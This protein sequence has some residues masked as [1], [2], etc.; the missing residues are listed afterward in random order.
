MGP[1]KIYSKNFDSAVIVF[2]Q[3]LDCDHTTTY[4]ILGEADGRVD[5]LKRAYGG[6]LGAVAPALPCRVHKGV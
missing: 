3:A 4:A 6:R 5:F 1:F 2:K